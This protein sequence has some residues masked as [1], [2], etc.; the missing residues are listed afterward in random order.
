MS[1]LP[2]YE[3][4]AIR[5]ASVDRPTRSNFL[6]G[7][8]PHDD[9]TMPMDFYVWLIRGENRVVLVDTG[10]NDISSS[11]RGR[12]YSCKP[13]VTLQGLGVHVEQVAD[14]IITHM[15]Y[16]HAGSVDVY[17]QVRIHL[18]ESEMQYATG[19]CM[20]DKKTN[21]FFYVEDVKTL[22]G[23]VYE[24][25]VQ[26]HDG[27]SDIYPGIQIER[28]GGHT[29]GLQIVRVH[30]RRGWIVLASDAAHYYRNFEEGNPFPAIH[31]ENEMA[32]G[33]DTIRRLAASADHII[34]GH[35]PEVARRYPQVRDLHAFSLHEAPLA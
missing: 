17:P 32:V 1:D 5:Y 10:F 25:N 33:Y 31:D 27:A 6:Y 12:Q 30:T 29:A 15:H 8:D 28:V 24:G 22:V 23:K 16:D 26:F 13:E 20:C 18:Q 34:P 7:Q 11:M 2:N 35:D 21:H 14:L 19:R 4:Y 9:S 3:V